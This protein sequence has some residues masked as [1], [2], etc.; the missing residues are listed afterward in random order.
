MTTTRARPLYRTD[1]RQRADRPTNSVILQYV[2]DRRLDFESYIYG[3]P[4]GTFFAASL[5]EIPYPPHIEEL[6]LQLHVNV[7]ALVDGPRLRQAVV[8]ALAAQ[9]TLDAPE[10]LNEL[11]YPN[12][13]WQDWDR[14]DLERR[15]RIAFAR[16][17]EVARLVEN[18]IR[19]WAGS[20][21]SEITIP[22][23]A[24]LLAPEPM[25][26][27]LVEREAPAPVAAPVA[28]PC[29]P[30][31]DFSEDDCPPCD[32]EVDPYAP[33]SQA[34]KSATAG[35]KAAREAELPQRLPQGARRR[36]NRMPPGAYVVHGEAI[37]PRR[38][39]CAA[40][41]DARVAG[42]KGRE[43]AVIDWDGEWPVVARRYGQ[44]GRTI[45]KVESVLKR[46]GIAVE[47]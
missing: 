31:A 2:G 27:R 15:H 40:M 41:T 47:A 46:H 3:Y 9:A 7:D 45:Y 17:A 22:D 14:R 29:P 11:A 16:V 30:A 12:V 23:I 21:M 34:V 19:L 35:V 26:M 25:S 42:R 5:A 28:A 1:I 37:D 32:D 13:C 20:R 10:L 33:A 36:L 18:D 39:L 44:G 6:A 38:D 8:E 24:A 43:A 4:T